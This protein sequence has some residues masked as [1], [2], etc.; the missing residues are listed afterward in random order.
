[1]LMFIVLIST[2]SVCYNYA[3]EILGDSQ[4]R[5]ISSSSTAFARISFGGNG[6]QILMIDLC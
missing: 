6:F 4:L 2:S 3:L 1:M 5:L